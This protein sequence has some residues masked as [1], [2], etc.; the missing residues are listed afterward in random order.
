MQE[1]ELTSHKFKTPNYLEL[2]KAA[3]ERIRSRS[4]D[5]QNTMQ[6]TMQDHELKTFESADKLF[7][8]LNESRDE[9]K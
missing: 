2:R 1:E 8:W 9:V 6:N 3:L 5:K 7:E 4:H